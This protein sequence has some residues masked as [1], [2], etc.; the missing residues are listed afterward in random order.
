MEIER[1][2]AR[3]IRVLIVFLAIG[4]CLGLY[5]RQKNKEVVLELGVF[6][7]SNWDVASANSFI[8]I[9]EAIA[10]FEE[11]HPGVKV[12]YYSGVLKEDY[13]EWFSRKLLEG[14]EPDVFMV[15]DTDFNQFCSMGVMKNLDELIQRDT[16][17]DE[18]RYFTSTYVSGKYQGS[19]YALPY[20]TVP[21]MMFVNKTLLTQ[22]GIEV[23]EEDWT[24]NDLYRICQKVTKD[25]NGDGIIDQFGIYNYNWKDAVYS[26][27]CD[28]FSDNGGESYFA[29]ERLVESVKF[30]RQL[31]E[32]NRGQKVMQEDF[33]GGNVAFMPLTFAEY[34]TY[35]TYPY[36]IKRYAN[37]TWDC[38]TMPAGDHGENVSEV[39]TLLMGISAH[40]QKEKLAWEFLKLL[41][42]DEEMQME[43][44]QYSQGASVLRNVTQSE[45]AENIIQEDMEKDD[46]V[47]DSAL[48]GKVIE[49]GR[50]EPKFKKYQQAIS[51]ADSEIGQILEEDKTLDSSLKILQRSVNSFLQQ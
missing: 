41:T 20:E 11:E 30:I 14:E 1:K 46:K 32:L 17:F 8:I 47:I 22:E 6:A 13:S 27:G 12:H 2:K 42:Y 25:S 21:T 36:K 18:N 34:R 43:L 38:I 15:L 9:D 28:I 5:F 31:T 19:Q 37:M 40:T 49:E 7:S 44:F 29:D 48:L 39:N 26:N 50:V 24:W 45:T 33:N 35:K 10:R 51:L 3:W 23:P 4:L 16:G